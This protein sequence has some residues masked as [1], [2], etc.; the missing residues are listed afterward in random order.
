MNEQYMRLRKEWR[1]ANDRA[2]RSESRYN[3]LQNQASKAFDI[4]DSLVEEIATCEVFLERLESQM[5]FQ[6]AFDHGYAFKMY[7]NDAKARAYDRIA[8]IAKRSNNYEC[9]L[10]RA[11]RQDYPD[12]D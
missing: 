4:R 8:E 11:R 1:E 10:Y 7:S 9:A 3:E 5:C 12:E 6:T 2:V